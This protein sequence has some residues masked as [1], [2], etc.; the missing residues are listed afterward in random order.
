MELAV[1]AALERTLAGAG[2]QGHDLIGT[3]L[4]TDRAGLLSSDQEPADFILQ[5]L[6]GA[7][8][9]DIGAGARQQVDDGL[10][11]RAC[12]TMLVKNSN[13]AVAGSPS[14]AS[15]LTW[16]VSRCSRSFIS[17]QSR[18]SLVGKCRN[19]VPIATPARRAT[20]SV[21]AEQWDAADGQPAGRRCGHRGAV[22]R[23][24]PAAAL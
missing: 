6:N 3:N 15:T 17:A 22:R 19:T 16:S 5:S 7:G 20:S 4:R 18:S 9:L 23:A 11:G 1:P 2:Q 12:S 10:P 13:S 24:G 8:D 21:V 14:A